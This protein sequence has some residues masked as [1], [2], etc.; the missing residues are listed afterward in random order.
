[1][2]E[3]VVFCRL[4]QFVYTMSWQDYV[5]K[6]LLASRC[7]TKAAIAGHDG[8]VWAKSEG[9]EVSA[10]IGFQSTCF[11]LGFGSRIGQP[12]VPRLTATSA[13]C[14]FVFY[15]STCLRETRKKLIFNTSVCFV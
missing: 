2:S 6:Q 8:N 3:I 9:F 10:N 13:R 7:V 5:D 12:F 14:S 11:E 15:T 1:M 4:E